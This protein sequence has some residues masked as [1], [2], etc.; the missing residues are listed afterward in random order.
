M[1]HL[2]LRELETSRD[3][4]NLLLEDLTWLKIPKLWFMVLSSISSSEVVR[5]AKDNLLIHGL[6]SPCNH[7]LLK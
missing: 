7:S 5:A 6:N 4:M 1:S 3:L 2:N